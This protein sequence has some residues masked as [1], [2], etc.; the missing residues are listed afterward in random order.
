MGRADVA[1]RRYMAD[2]ARFADAFN[3]AI[4]GGEEVIVPNALTP[5]DSVSLEPGIGRRRNSERRRDG[6]KLWQA[7]GD[8]RA[9]YA[10]LGV[11]DQTAIHY[12]MPVRCMTYDAP[13][14]GDQIDGIRRK[15]RAQEGMTGAEWLSGVRKEDRLLPVVTLVLHFGSERWDGPRRL[16]EML[17]PADEVLVS[18]VPDYRINLVSPAS[19]ADEGFRK[20][21]T[22]LGVV[23]G[24][25]KYA[26]DK[27]GLTRYMNH[28]SRFK[29]VGA[30][31][32]EL[33]NELTDSRLRIAEGEEMV[34][35][36]KAIE[37]MRA[38]AR[39]EGIEQ[40]I[41]QGT[42]QVLSGLVRD[43]VLTLADAAARAGVAPEE[44]RKRVTML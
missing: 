44:F 3:Y 16:H 13:A 32:V 25:I 31:S 38:E 5:L 27:D 39:S 36:C 12:G 10:L 17:T 29:S 33:I 7:M 37:D 26:Q 35:M 1:A 28:E 23:L 14:Y 42:M 24:Y 2:P 34:D 41:E 8:G 20:F 22:E 19:M 15:R 9:A 21:R 30:E 6:L 40:G 18:L 11:E 4:Y 43:G